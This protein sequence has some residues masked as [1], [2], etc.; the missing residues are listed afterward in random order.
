[1]ILPLALLLQAAAL[2][3][4]TVKNGTTVATVPVV[5]MA[6]GPM[7]RA[8]LLVA[9][10][11][12]ELR[13]VA[14][15]R[16]VVRVGD[17]SFEITSRVP[18]AR[19]GDEAI[20]LGFEPTVQDG[21]LYL[22]FAFVS[23]VLPRL[24]SSVVYDVKRAELRRF[25]V[26]VSHPPPVDATPAGARAP[27][28]TARGGSRP[29]RQIVV[30]DAGHGG[31]DKGMSGPIGASWTI[32]EKDITLKVA[33]ELRAALSERG[34]DV[35]MTRTTDTLIALSDRG[36]IAN[37]RK[38]DVF[39]S[40]HVNAASPRWKQPGAAR[41]VETYFLSE[42]R[43]ED[44]RRVEQM[45]NEVVKYEAAS[46]TGANDPLSF[47]VHDMEQNQHLRESSVFAAAI[48]HGLVR[49]HPAP[50]R[51]VK[52]AGFRVLV[53]ALM[54]AVLVEIGFGSNAADAR[55]VSS[56]EGQRAIAESIADATAQYLS[57][58]ERRSG[59]AGQ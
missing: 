26:V 25:A 44:D 40:I 38:G 43:T 49:V 57:Q 48:Q 28:P 47:I 34:I 20:P 7:V 54:P 1:V 36:R 27:A 16:Y 42:A 10:L 4:V 29:R 33:K 23:D 31:P 51:G 5:L 58:Y 9:S 11:D 8:D 15:G 59:A 41:G 30:V 53:T 6:Q 56:R 35:V 14:D 19:V 12:G 55:Y 13:A 46:R 21:K 37:E 52:Q 45:E 3:T 50:D 22:P 24:A 2:T 17:V 39:I 18:V 32:Y